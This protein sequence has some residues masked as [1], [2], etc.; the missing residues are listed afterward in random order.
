MSPEQALECGT[1]LLEWAPADRV[2]QCEGGQP[3]LTSG[4][5]TYTIDDPHWNP[6]AAPFSVYRDEGGGG[7][8]RYF[9]TPGEAAEGVR[10]WLRDCLADAEAEAADL[11]SV[12]ND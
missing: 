11:R 5:A 1:L 7:D 12:I 8:W 6:K 3:R 10:E 4:E 9:A 2:D